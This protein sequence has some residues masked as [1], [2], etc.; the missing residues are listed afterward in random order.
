MNGHWLHLATALGLAAA[1]G[2]NLTLP[3]L[4]LGLAAAAGWGEAAGPYS[5]LGSAGLLT[6][7]AVL[8]L[9]EWLA[10]KI[11]VLDLRLH[12]LLLPGALVV[13]GWLAGG[14]AA[15]I[16]PSATGLVVALGV[17][18]AGGLHLARSTIRPV[19]RLLP[20]GVGGAALSTLEDVT[21]GVLIL[22]ALGAPAL[23][24]LL[25]GALWVAWGV[26]VGVLL[27]LGLGVARQGRA[28]LGS[29]VGVGV[30]RLRGGL[31]PLEGVVLPLAPVAA[32]PSPL[33][34]LPD[35]P[36]E[37]VWDV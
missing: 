8:A 22:L 30:D 16:L 29:L 20:L 37:D 2:L 24:P 28:L 31:L 13:G 35:A 32:L 10:D 6:V 4:L 15:A 11:P 1:A 18:T 23:A 14:Q 25:V 7:V 36:G 33:P 19:V 21:A 9:I 12:T 27:R 17:A 5:G 3:L 26:A 34:P